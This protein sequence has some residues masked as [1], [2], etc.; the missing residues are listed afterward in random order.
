MELEQR[1]TRLE[2]RQVAVERDIKEIKSQLNETAK[3]SDVERLERTL[4]ERDANYTRHLWKLIFILIAVFTAIT[5]AAVGLSVA[6]ISLPTML[7][8]GS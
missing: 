4:N 6:D 1:V 8:G 5:L 2:E 3:R 7:G